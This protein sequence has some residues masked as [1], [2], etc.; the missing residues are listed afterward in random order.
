MSSPRSILTASSTE[1]NQSYF[2]CQPSSARALAVDTCT[3]I[4]LGIATSAYC[5][6]NA[7][8]RYGRATSYLIGSGEATLNGSPEEAGCSSTESMKDT[9]SRMSTV[10]GFQ[11]FPHG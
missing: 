2:G 3:L 5:L 7:V 10:C 1:A 8:A 4:S 6:T 11:T 9:R